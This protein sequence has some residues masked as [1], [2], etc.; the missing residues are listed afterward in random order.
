MGTGVGGGIAFGRLEGL[1]ERTGPTIQRLEVSTDASGAITH[2]SIEID[3]DHP[4]SHEQVGLSVFTPQGLAYDQVLDLPTVVKWYDLRELSTRAGVPLPTAL[5]EPGTLVRVAPFDHGRAVQSRDLLALQVPLDA[6]LGEGRY[7]FG[8]W[9]AEWPSSLWN[10]A[11]LSGAGGALHR[12]FVTARTEIY[13]HGIPWRVYPVG[14]Q[15]EPLLDS[16]LGNGKAAIVWEQ[17]GFV[18]IDLT[19][20]V[21][22]IPWTDLRDVV[23]ELDAVSQA[24]PGAQPRRLV[25]PVSAR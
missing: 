14:H 12:A 13:Q 18:G 17:N 4:E 5:T 6:P 15:N 10:S 24:D 25:L 21:A 8:A 9:E 11:F 7:L 1:T 3:R 22:T 20:D 19:P 23:L 2:L 16:W